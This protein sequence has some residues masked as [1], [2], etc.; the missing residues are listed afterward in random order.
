MSVTEK[1]VATLEGFWRPKVDIMMIEPK[2]GSGYPRPFN[3]PLAAGES[4]NVSRAE[5]GFDLNASHVVVPYEAF[6][7]DIFG[8]A[9][10]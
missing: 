2:R 5:G 10:V 1:L 4:R 9:A 6:A 7:R 8:A 3:L